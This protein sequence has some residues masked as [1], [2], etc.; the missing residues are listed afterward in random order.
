[1]NEEIKKLK[2][3]MKMYDYNFKVL[4]GN[5]REN[6]QRK[7]TTRS[8]TISNAQSEGSKAIILGDGN[9]SPKEVT[10]AQVFPD[11]TCK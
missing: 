8:T 2:N 6:S 1:M 7:E 9:R 4:E 10:R 11:S 5:E 3:I